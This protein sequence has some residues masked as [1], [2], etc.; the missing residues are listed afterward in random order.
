[1]ITTCNRGIAVLG[2]NPRNATIPGSITCVPSY[3]ANIC[4]FSRLYSAGGIAC[5][6]GL[7]NDTKGSATLGVS[8]PPSYHPAPTVDF[9]DECFRRFVEVACS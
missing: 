2:S 4:F 6:I 9:A 7:Q 8:Y 1:M 3:P 5:V